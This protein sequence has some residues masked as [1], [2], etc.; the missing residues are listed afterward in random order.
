MRL[1]LF[2]GA[3]FAV[4][5]IAGAMMMFGTTLFVGPQDFNHMGYTII[6]VVI[7]IKIYF[8]MDKHIKLTDVTKD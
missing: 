2:F 7:N 4:T 5:Q 6:M 1:L 8:I 3:W